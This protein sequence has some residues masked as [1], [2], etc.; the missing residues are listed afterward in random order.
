MKYKKVSTKF[1][2]MRQKIQKLFKE[3]NTYKIFLKV[4]Y[5]K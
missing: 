5:K 1:S 2:I 4:T 3:I